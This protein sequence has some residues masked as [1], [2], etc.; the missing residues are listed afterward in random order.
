MNYPIFKIISECVIKP[1]FLSEEA[2]KPTYLSPWDLAMLSLH[3][4]QKGLLYPLPNNQDF[5]I[6]TFLDDLKVSFSAK[7]TH[8]RRS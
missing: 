3:Y 6:N 5:S 7:L 1:S 2:K 8:F 4:I